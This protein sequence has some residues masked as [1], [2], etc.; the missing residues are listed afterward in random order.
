MN[1]RKRKRAAITPPISLTYPE[2]LEPPSIRKR[3]TDSSLQDQHYLNK[4]KRLQGRC[5]L[6]FARCAKRNTHGTGR[7]D[8]TSTLQY[9]PKRSFLSRL[10]V[11]I[12]YGRTKLPYGRSREVEFTKTLG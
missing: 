9:A 4:I 1:V 8:V 7:D 12:I 3:K 10:R 11:F 6:R 2:F 5:D